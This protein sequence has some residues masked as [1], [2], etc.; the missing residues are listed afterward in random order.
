[1][2]ILNCDFV[3]TTEHGNYCCLKDCACIEEDCRIHELFAE[4]QRYHNIG[5]VEEL[6]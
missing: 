3:E 5:T 4:L 1:M 6:Q 2:K